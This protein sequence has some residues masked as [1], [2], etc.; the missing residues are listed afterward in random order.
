MR[1][2]LICPDEKLR[3]Q[4]ETAAASHVN[5]VFSKVLTDYPSGDAATRLIRA[6]VPEVIFLSVEHAE[7]AEHLNRRLEVEFPSIPRIALSSSQSPEVFR[8]ALRLHM[9]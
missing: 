2:I 5:L 9:Q 8:F 4:F 6:W 1:A 7:V 3:T